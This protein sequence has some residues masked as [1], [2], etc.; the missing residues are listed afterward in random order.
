ML[1]HHAATRIFHPAFVYL[2]GLLVVV[3]VLFRRHAAATGGHSPWGLAL[4][5]LQGQLLCVPHELLPVSQRPQLVQS[6]CARRLG[7]AGL[8][9]NS[10]LVRY[11]Q[12][13]P[14]HPPPAEFLVCNVNRNVKILVRATSFVCFSMHAVAK[15]QSRMALPR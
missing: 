15:L 13:R 8:E 14:A 5:E 11:V 10:I 4:P 6:G 7:W 3:V 1:P 2:F 12:H 9:C